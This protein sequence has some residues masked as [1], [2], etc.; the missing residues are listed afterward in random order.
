MGGAIFTSEPPTVVKDYDELLQ[1]YDKR[2]L[3]STPWLRDQAWTH[4]CA[5]CDIPSYF[6][7]EVEAEEF[8]TVLAPRIMQ[9]FERLKALNAFLGDPE[10]VAVSDGMKCILRC[11][12]HGKM[13]ELAKQMNCSLKVFKESRAH[14]P[15]SV[16]FSAHALEAI[17]DEFCAD[18]PEMKDALATANLE[19]VLG[20]AAKG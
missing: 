8:S 11:A 4:I 2:V 19:S 9:V 6:L 14:V 15:E 12:I 7:E 18:K 3:S 1:A 13:I 17:F 10:L 5:D 16:S 20:V